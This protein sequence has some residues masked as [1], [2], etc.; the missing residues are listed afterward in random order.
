MRT[1]SGTDNDGSAVSLLSEKIESVVVTQLFVGSA[2]ETREKKV[3]R[4][5]P[6]RGHVGGGAQ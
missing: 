4:R 3:G 6:E 1:E 2:E 5:F